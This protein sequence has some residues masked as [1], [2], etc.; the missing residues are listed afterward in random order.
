MFKSRFVFDIEDGGGNG[1]SQFSNSHYP[2]DSRCDDPK[3]PVCPE[4]AGSGLTFMEFLLA[5]EQM[6]S[7]QVENVSEMPPSPT[8][9]EQPHEGVSIHDIVEVY[10]LH[11]LSVTNIKVVVMKDGSEHSYYQNTSETITVTPGELA[12]VRRAR[13]GALER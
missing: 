6:S 12:T 5:L 13:H 9:S 2:P 4:G 11:E 7:P 8:R 10:D 3:C 1:Y